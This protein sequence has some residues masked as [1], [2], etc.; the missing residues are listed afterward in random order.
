MPA[1]ARRLGTLPMRALAFAG[2]LAASGAGTA[3][4]AYW[5]IFN[6]EGESGLASVIVTYAT[7]ADMLND[8]N[9]TGGFNPGGVASNVVGTGADL[10]RRPPV[11]VPEP[12]TLALLASGLAALGLA[13]RPR[14]G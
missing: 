1:T 5:N 13:R 2:A 12:G 3:H 8:T 4:A 10:M 7:L 14:R 9:R 6:L 11:N